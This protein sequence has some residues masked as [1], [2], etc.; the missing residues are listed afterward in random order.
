MS[1]LV[2][3]VKNLFG[4]GGDT[5]T[6]GADAIRRQAEIARKTREAQ[7]VAVARQRQELQNQKATDQTEVR[8]AR[9]TPPGRRLLFAAT[10][11]GGLSAKLGG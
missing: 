4:G 9:R 3:S 8:R 11:E 1:G 6:A 5:G 2:R 10:G 7:Q